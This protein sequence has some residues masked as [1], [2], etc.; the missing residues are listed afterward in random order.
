[1]D[2]LQLCGSDGRTQQLTFQRPTL[3]PEPCL[4]AP[5]QAPERMAPLGDLR[6]DL[7]YAHATW[8]RDITLKDANEIR[9]RGIGQDWFTAEMSAIVN[10]RVAA[11]DR[12]FE[13][14]EK[15]YQEWLS[16]DEDRQAIKKRIDSGLVLDVEFALE[17]ERLRVTERSAADAVD[18]LASAQ[19]RAALLARSAA[20]REDFLRWYPR[21]IHCTSRRVLLT[22]YTTCR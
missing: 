8:V 9:M 18:R 21:P 14:T 22:V 2:D 1:M 16:C 6:P 19:F 15:A 3:P 12:Y 5:P 11:A 10:A 4:F 20:W 17:I 7:H 13:G